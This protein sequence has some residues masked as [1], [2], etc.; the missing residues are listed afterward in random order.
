VSFIFGTHTHIQTNDERILKNGTGMIC[1][2]WM[3]GPLN[4]V[5]W[6]DFDSVKNRFLTG[7]NKWKME[8][9][10]WKE[11]VVSWIFVEIWNN[12]KCEKLE[13]IRI[14]NEGK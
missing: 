14:V 3:S 2:V 1:D 13:K 7:I 9:A 12:K 11:Y 5:I 4:S 6:I 10:L 8:Q